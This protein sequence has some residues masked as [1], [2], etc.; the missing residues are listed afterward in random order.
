MVFFER[1]WGLTISVQ[2]SAANNRCSA[3]CLNSLPQTDRGAQGIFGL[4]NAKQSNCN[5]WLESAGRAGRP[6]SQTNGGP[7]APRSGRRDQ[8]AAISRTWI[9]WGL[10]PGISQVSPETLQLNP[11]G[12]QV[13]PER[14]R[15]NP[16]GLQVYPER[17]QVNPEGLQV[18]PERQRVNPE[19]LRV[20][21]QCGNVWRM[22]RCHAPE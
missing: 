11:E 17:L 16:E 13:S 22:G 14:L 2:L 9:Q 6:G 7:H 12:L 10:A 15:V 21:P 5:A 8:Q 3:T 4:E 19:G 20:C 18:S 1:I